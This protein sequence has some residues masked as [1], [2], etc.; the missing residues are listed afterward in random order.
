MPDPQMRLDGQQWAI[1]RVGIP[2]LRQQRDEPGG[3]GRSQLGLT[4]VGLA[5]VGAGAD[6]PPA[7]ELRR[8][9]LSHGETAQRHCRESLPLAHNG[10]GRRAWDS[11]RTEPH[12][13][14][15]ASTDPG[16]RQEHG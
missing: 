9:S 10:I 2:G 8:D 7:G 15:E 12:A 6:A 11:N 4:F 1:G 13:V 5:P 16:K 14:L 3:P